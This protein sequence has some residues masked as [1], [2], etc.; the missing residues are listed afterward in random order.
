MQFWFCRF[1]SGIFGVANAPHTG[2]PVV[3]NF[4]TITETIE[5]HRHVSSRSIGLELKIDH[6]TVLNHLRIVGLKRKLDVWVPHQMTPKNMMGRITK[7]LA[8]RNKIDPYLK[9]L[10]AGDD[11]WVTYDNAV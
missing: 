8:K 3:E 1:R 6:K 5:V 11:K 7:A 4:D 10:V 9:R 2:R